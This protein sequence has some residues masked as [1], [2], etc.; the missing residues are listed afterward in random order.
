MWST[1]IFSFYF[2]RI[3]YTTYFFIKYWYN[4]TCHAI[5]VQILVSNT[6]NRIYYTEGVF[7]SSGRTR[8]T[9]FDSHITVM[10]SRQYHINC[11]SVSNQI[12]S[13]QRIWRLRA[14]VKN[15]LSADDRTKAHIE[16]AKMRFR[17]HSYEYILFIICRSNNFH[18][19]NAS[20]TLLRRHRQELLQRMWY[21]VI[22]SDSLRI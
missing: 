18:Q 11:L 3:R 7:T 1:N 17:I 4:H 22:P 15:A 12:C 14:H 13:L 16:S 8:S 5:W 10:F 6:I 19:F 2:C 9:L 21:S 20:W